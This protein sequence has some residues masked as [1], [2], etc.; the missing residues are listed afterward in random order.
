MSTVRLFLAGDVMTGRGIDQVLRRPSDP[1]LLEPFVGDARSYVELA[2]HKSGRIPRRAAPAY[3]WGDALAELE[4]ERPDVRIVNLETS[5]TTSDAFWPGKS[6]HY[7][8]H[9]ENIDCLTVAR[10][11]CC[12]LANNHVLDFGR[13]GLRETLQALRRAGLG[14][15]GAG[16]N[17]DRAAAPCDV[18][19]PAKCRVRVYA[20][21]FGTSGIPFAWAAGKAS[22]G[23]N[24][25]R[26]PTADAG[27]R[28]GRLMRS[29]RSPGD[30]VVASVHWGGNWGFAIPP[31]ER[32]FAHALID[33]GG[34]D[35]VHGH[36]SHHPKAIEI[37][38]GKPILY[39]CGDLIT[40][41]EGI[42]GHETYR[43]DLSPMY[44][45]DIDS[46]GGRLVDLTIVTLRLERF[47]LRPAAPTDVAWLVY[48]LNRD[49]RVLGSRAE[50]APGGRII[51]RPA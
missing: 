43:P 46:D 40:D 1:R 34:A 26:F 4:R 51:V 2:E 16:E 45:V 21:G 50:E 13:E 11:D 23:V 33:S 14:I 29:A 3:I 35:V 27:A 28:V 38:R 49:G 7:R 10:V 32:A 19:V 8:M 36:S 47:S 18:D 41:Y 48:R 9:P 6:I 42:G 25:L 30:V 24:L 20:L 12:V 17:A 15:A 22:P 5:V 44:F 37:Y 31:G 39:G